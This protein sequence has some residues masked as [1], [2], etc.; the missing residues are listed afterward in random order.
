MVYTPSDGAR[1]PVRN[2]RCT[3]TYPRRGGNPGEEEE[4][5][6]RGVQPRGSNRL[7]TTDS[8]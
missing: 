6:V 5:S 3:A 7:A 2:V 4:G 1:T 8:Q